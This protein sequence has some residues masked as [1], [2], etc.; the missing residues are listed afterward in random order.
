MSKERPPTSYL[1]RVDPSDHVVGFFGTAGLSAAVAGTGFDSQ[2]E[3][4]TLIR[5]FR[6]P[7][8]KVSLRAHARIRSVLKEVAVASGII[9]RQEVSRTDPGTGTT[10]KVSAAARI[11]GRMKGLDVKIPVTETGRPDFAARY[12]PASAPKDHGG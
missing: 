11:A 4:E 5:H 2:E 1:D 3:M 12:L 6:D 10:V 8:P 9:A 7:D